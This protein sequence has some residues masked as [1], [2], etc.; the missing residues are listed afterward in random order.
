[1]IKT[2]SIRDLE[3]KANNIYEAIVVLAKRARQ[4]NSEQK[5]LLI[6]E[7]DYDEYE[8]FQDEEVDPDVDE[9]F[10]DLPKPPAVSLDE[11]LSGKIKFEYSPEEDKKDDESQ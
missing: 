9:T 4:I 6:Q 5:H 3:A 7:R 10:L 2:M 1:M 11:F 8:E